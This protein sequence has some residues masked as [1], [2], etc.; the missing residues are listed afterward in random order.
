MARGLGDAAQH[1]F[2]QHMSNQRSV[3]IVDDNDD[4]RPLLHQALADGGYQVEVAASATEALG[5]VRRCTIDLAVVDLVLR[6]TVT[7]EHLAD[8]L[9]TLGIP[10][11][12]ISG[13]VNA[14]ER[15]ALLPY[16]FLAKPFR[17]AALTALIETRLDGAPPGDGEPG[18]AGRASSPP[19]RGGIPPSDGPRMPR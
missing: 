1:E 16:P 18:K 10:V 4:V 14:A 11:I 7:G 5:L 19:D 8:I 2:E 9:T 3:L 15:L 17:V 12:M 6:G 13:L